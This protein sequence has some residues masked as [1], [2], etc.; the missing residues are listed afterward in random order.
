M[1]QKFHFAPTG[2]LDRVV[3]EKK[4]HRKP[5]DATLMYLKHL[6]SASTVSVVRPPALKME[7]VR[8]LAGTFDIASR[9]TTP[10]LAIWE[11]EFENYVTSRKAR[12]KE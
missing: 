11:Q 12:P 9:E 5:L 6:T 10:D 2:E 3:V 1:S 8:N 7:L 4:V